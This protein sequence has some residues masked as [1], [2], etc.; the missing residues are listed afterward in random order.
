M[1]NSNSVNVYKK[2][3]LIPHQHHE[4]LESKIS[5]SHRE[6]LKQK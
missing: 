5:Q 1:R 2:C 3:I 6:F 4:L